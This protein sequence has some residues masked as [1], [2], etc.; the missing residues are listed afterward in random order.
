VKVA[1]GPAGIVGGGGGRE[2]IWSAHAS[3]Q[4]LI[5]FS[6][7]T[8]LTNGDVIVS[9]EILTVIT[10]DL[11]VALPFSKANKRSWGISFYSYDP[12]IFFFQ[13]T[14]RGKWNFKAFIIICSYM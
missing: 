2:R 4:S 14:L 7:M 1:G 10:S 11:Q 13:N 6:G 5:F 9:V 3:G 12:Q 8:L